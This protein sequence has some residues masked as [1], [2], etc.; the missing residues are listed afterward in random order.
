MKVFH[1]FEI[2]ANVLGMDSIH[3]ISVHRLLGIDEPVQFELK[4]FN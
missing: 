2:Y 1:V 3:F 4:N